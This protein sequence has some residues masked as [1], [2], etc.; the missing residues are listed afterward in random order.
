MRRDADDELVVVGDG[1]NMFVCST[2]VRKKINLDAK[3][4]RLGSCSVIFTFNSCA[5]LTNVTCIDFKVGERD[6]AQN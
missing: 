2:K 3:N 1:R 5:L 4:E 6:V